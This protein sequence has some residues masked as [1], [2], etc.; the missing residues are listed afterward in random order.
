MK[1]FIKHENIH[2]LLKENILALT[3]NFNN[4]VQEFVRTIV[5]KDKDMHVDFYNY[6]VEFQMRGAGHIHGVLWMDIPSL[7]KKIRWLG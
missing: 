3:K 7:E 2:E 4:R 5:L 1:D 6:R